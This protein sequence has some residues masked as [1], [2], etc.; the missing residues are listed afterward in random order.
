MLMQSLLF[1]GPYGGVY[2]P[3]DKK[4]TVLHD[5]RPLKRITVFDP[6]VR[7]PKPARPY[8]MLPDDL[9]GY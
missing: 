8:N 1:V 7:Y 6:E 5:A 9:L 3:T 4:K 2:R